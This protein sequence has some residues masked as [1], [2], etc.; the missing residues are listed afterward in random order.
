MTGGQPDG[1][2]HGLV[3]RHL[4][5]AQGR[6]QPPP[7]IHEFNASVVAPLHSIDFGLV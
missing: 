2:T 3:S 1:R 4:E 6:T 5:P 7:L